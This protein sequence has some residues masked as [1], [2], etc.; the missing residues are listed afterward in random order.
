MFFAIWLLSEDIMAS[1]AAAQEQTFIGPGLS[2]FKRIMTMLGVLGVTILVFWIA[3]HQGAPAIGSTI[4]AVLF[5]LGF[6][7]YLRLIAP[8]PF[9]ISLEPAALVKRSKNGEFIE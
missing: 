9:T 1:P 7:I 2:R 6:L 4:V 8:V 5:I 3:L